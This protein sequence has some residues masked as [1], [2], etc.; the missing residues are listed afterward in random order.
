MLKSNYHS[1][2]LSHLLDKQRINNDLVRVTHIILR[3]SRDNIYL[4][5]DFIRHANA[6]LYLFVFYE[7]S[8]GLSR[9]NISDLKW[10]HYNLINIEIIFVSNKFSIDQILLER[11]QKTNDEEEPAVVISHEDW[12]YFCHALGY[13]FLQGDYITI[14]N[15]I[16]N[17][18]VEHPPINAQEVVLESEQI[19]TTLSMNDVATYI[20]MEL[21]RYRL[22]NNSEPS[23]KNYPLCYELKDSSLYFSKED[24]IKVNSLLQQLSNL[25][26]PQ[27]IFYWPVI[28]QR[29]KKDHLSDYP[30]LD[31]KNC[32]YSASFKISLNQTPFYQFF[33]PSG[34]HEKLKTI[35]DLILPFHSRQKK[36]RSLLFENS[37]NSDLIKI[38]AIF[39]N[40]SPLHFKISPLIRAEWAIT[41]D[42]KRYIDLSWPSFFQR[43]EKFGIKIIDHP[44]VPLFSTISSSWKAPKKDNH[45]FL[46][47]MSSLGVVYNWFANVPKHLLSKLIPTVQDIAYITKQLKSTGRTNI[48]NDAIWSIGD[49]NWVK[50]KE[51]KGIDS[52]LSEKTPYSTSNLSGW[53]GLKRK[54]TVTYKNIEKHSL[55][56]K[57]KTAEI[58]MK[59]RFSKHDIFYCFQDLK[60][61]LAS[62]YDSLV[63]QLLVSHRVL[64]LLYPMKRLPCD[65]Q[66]IDF[67]EMQVNPDDIGKK[68]HLKLMLKNGKI[69]NVFPIVHFQN[70]EH[71]DFWRYNNI[72]I[73]MDKLIS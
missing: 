18:G 33:L 51:S 20:N 31:L 28:S 65:S 2:Y 48:L 13:F 66:D 50:S 7:G 45:T 4:F 72:E 12:S 27:V 25:S 67:V 68:L 43:I 58:V 23:K 30:I 32:A 53:N 49:R 52:L 39:L 5:Y 42:V 64:P 60:V 69:S 55:T 73:E 37:L 46:V 56:R 34:D 54:L 9:K 40:I 71:Y 61:T 36:I 21:N 41:Y 16:L 70:W 63:Y 10:A 38:V 3:I 6:S 8:Q 62:Y 11:I 26:F 29:S 44:T 59:D 22:Q 14:L 19:A 47:F 35:E 24:K 15:C 57:V 1:I 17:R